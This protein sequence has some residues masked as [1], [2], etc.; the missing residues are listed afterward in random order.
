MRLAASTKTFVG[1]VA[2]LGLELVK[3][4]FFAAR[5]AEAGTFLFLDDDYDTII[6]ILIIRIFSSFCALV[7]RSNLFLK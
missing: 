6:L 5:V 1:I 7:L 2:F 4:A 3:I